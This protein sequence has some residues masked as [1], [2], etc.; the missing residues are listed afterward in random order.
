MT[1]N[2]L[3]KNLKD[4]R[5]HLTKQRSDEFLRLCKEYLKKYHQLHDFK[6]KLSQENRVINVF[7]CKK[8]PC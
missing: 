3:R 6:V 4:L 5:A 2:E 8:P 7:I 1:K